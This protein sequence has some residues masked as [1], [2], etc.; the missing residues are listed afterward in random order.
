M[1]THKTKAEFEI[2]KEKE[3]FTIEKASIVMAMAEC[4]VPT[5]PAKEPQWP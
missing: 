2:R 3:N 4:S 1:E 5:E